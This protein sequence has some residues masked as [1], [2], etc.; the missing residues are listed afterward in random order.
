[1]PTLTFIEDDGTV[2]MCRRR[3]DASAM[4][5]VVEALM[6]GITADCGGARACDACHDMWKAPPANGLHAPMD[7]KRDMAV[8]TDDCRPSSPA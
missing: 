7:D 4:Q 6:P 1:M 2:H 3:F 8:C 5:A